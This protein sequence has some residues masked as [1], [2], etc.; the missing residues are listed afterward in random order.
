MAPM[1]NI[2]INALL[3]WFL[4]II[5]KANSPIQFVYILSKTGLN[6]A[7]SNSYKQHVSVM[8]M[9]HHT[10]DTSG[11]F[12]V[13]GCRCFMGTLHITYN[14][15]LPFSSYRC[16]SAWWDFHLGGHNASKFPIILSF[17]LVLPDTRHEP[18]GVEIQ[19]F[20]W[21]LRF[22]IYIVSPVFY[23]SI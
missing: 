10:E 11:L 14:T 5:E 15:T 1:K 6:S 20:K 9:L 18:A 2:S 19:C 21:D 22:S 8:G 17:S 3:L 23:V 4:H 13:S 7:R 16:R 12:A